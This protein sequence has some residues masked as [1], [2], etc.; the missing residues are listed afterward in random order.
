[1]LYSA[2]SY[3]FTPKKSDRAA[4]SPLG[5]KSAILFLILANQNPKRIANEYK[6]AIKRLKDSNGMQL[7]L[8]PLGESN[9]D[10]QIPVSESVSSMVEDENGINVSFRQVYQALCRWAS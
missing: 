9:K 10:F 1:M 6:E 4:P 7:P 8:D 3:L 5:D 2:Y